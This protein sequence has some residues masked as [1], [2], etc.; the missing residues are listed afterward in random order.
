M[1]TRLIGLSGFAG[2]GKDTLAQMLVE[3]HGFKRFAFADALKSMLYSVN[4]K[5]GDGFTLKQTVD[6]LGWD[7]AKQF[8]EVRQLLQRLGTAVCDVQPLFW[9]DVTM[10]QV[11]A[12][13]GPAVVTDVRLVQEPAAFAARNGMLVQVARDGV[14]PVNSHKSE[15]EWARFDFDRIVHN[16]TLDE[17][18]LEAARMAYCTV[19]R[20]VR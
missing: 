11:D 9:V 8:P 19:W 14:G 2:S 13:S 7:D 17:L 15:H 16:T 5:L 10:V 12:W 6:A 18:R 3:D 4:P 1:A 20:S